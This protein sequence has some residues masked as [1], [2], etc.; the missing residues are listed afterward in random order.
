MWLW[1]LKGIDTHASRNRIDTHVATAC[2]SYVLRVPA[3]PACCNCM[4]HVA[5]AWCT[6]M[7]Q[8]HVVVVCCNSMLQLHAAIA[9]CDCILHLHAATASRG[10]NATT[11]TQPSVNYLY[12]G[13]TFRV[14]MLLSG[15]RDQK[16][17]STQCRYQRQ[18]SLI[19]TIVA[20]SDIFFCRY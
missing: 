14:R 6:C 19:A 2:C 13:V 4:L 17:T 3:A 1:R 7:Q 16:T 20:N 8:M 12:H 5:V 10:T 18:L 15:S 11:A 9:R